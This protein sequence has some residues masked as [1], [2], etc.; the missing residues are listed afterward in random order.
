MEEG[1]Q[2]L[3]TIVA[4]RGMYVYLRTDSF[5]IPL[6]GFCKVLC[7]ESDIARLL[8]FLRLFQ[9]IYRLGRRRRCRVGCFLRLGLH[10]LFMAFVKYLFETV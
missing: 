4:N 9:R 1:L 7:S 3:R 2:Y 8:L 10:I 6:N 5:G